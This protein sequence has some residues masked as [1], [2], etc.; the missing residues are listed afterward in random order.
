M[1]LVCTGL[2]SELSFSLLVVGSCHSVLPDS[3]DKLVVSTAVIGCQKTIVLPTLNFMKESCLSSPSCG[4]CSAVVVVLSSGGW[5]RG[6]LGKPHELPSPSR[7][8]AC[9]PSALDSQAGLQITHS[10]RA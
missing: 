5:G 8:W 10:D 4:K 9:L 3:G 2:T 6:L 7:L 1:F